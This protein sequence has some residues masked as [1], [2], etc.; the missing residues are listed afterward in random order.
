M[1]KSDNR[2]C[3][4]GFNTPVRGNPRI[5]FDR[6]KL[7]SIAVGIITLVIL[8]MLPTGYEEAAAYKGVDRV[9]ARVKQTD[10]S[11]MR[12]TGLVR[13]GEQL[14]EIEIL[15]GSFK[16][17][18]VRAVNMLHG[19][20]DSDKIYAPGDKA[21]VLVSSLDE[22]IISVSMIDHY[23][24][25]IELILAGIFILLLILLA[26][27]TGARAVLSFAITVLAIWKVLVPLFLN[28]VNPI[29]IGMAF[30]VFI[31]VISLSLVYGFDS[32]CF[33][34]SAG[35]ILGVI[36]T[37]VIGVIFTKLLNIHGAVMP[38]SQTLLY[39]G[40][41]YLNLTE[42]FKAAIFIGAA[43]AMTD[44]SVDIT[45]AVHEVVEQV[46][47]IKWKAAAK[48]GFNV[49][50]NAMGTMVTTLLLA[51]SG[52]YI[53]LLMTFMAQ[54]T[55]IYNIMNY[56]G[57]S[58]EILTTLA[59]SIGLVTVAPF[60]ALVSGFLLTYKKKEM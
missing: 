18:N 22:Q 17:Q 23:R 51:Y 55:P 19:S 58:A 29:S 15:S 45:S 56:K 30:A 31:T 41:E 40:F 8:I 37:S 3:E 39:S 7:I 28:G 2:S 4:D 10:E 34:A 26:G 43:G 33:A 12:N 25:H 44:L 9:S 5:K 20:L 16:G 42:I 35:A 59:G 50:R 14:C 54:G 11:R 48:S 38:Y 1:K 53:I 47:G 52:G 60:T 36:T 32:R 57:V 27:A 21:L 24:I 6:K 13:I 49:G 46:P